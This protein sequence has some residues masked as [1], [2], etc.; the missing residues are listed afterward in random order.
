[1]TGF[2][3]RQTVREPH[4]DAARALRQR[5]TP[6]E[7]RFWQQLRGSKLE[8]MRFRRQQPIGPYIVDFY[9]D[10]IGLVVEVDGPIHEQQVEYDRERDAY[11]AAHDL[12]VLRFTNEAVFSDLERSLATIRRTMASSSALVAGERLPLR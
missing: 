7:Q 3:R 12:K 5:Q 6:A 2:V 8:G 1:M 4:R 9:C 11:L 10:A